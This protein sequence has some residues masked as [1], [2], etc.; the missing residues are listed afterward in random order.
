MRESSCFPIVGYP[1]ARQPLWMA[2]PGTITESGALYD[3][4]HSV[5]KRALPARPGEA[6]PKATRTVLQNAKA[7]SCASLAGEVLT[8]KSAGDFRFGLST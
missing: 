7:P 3:A 8:A 4:L 6:R 2:G 1:E 5:K